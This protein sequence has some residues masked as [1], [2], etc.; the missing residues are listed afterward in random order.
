MTN[1]C[2]SDQGGYDGEGHDD[3]PKG[4]QPAGGLH[5]V[6]DAVESRVF[7]EESPISR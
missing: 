6:P 7:L 1:E 5:G 2:A 4:A 3:Q